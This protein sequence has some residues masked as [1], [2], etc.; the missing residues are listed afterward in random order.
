MRVVLILLLVLF[1]L[2]VYGSRRSRR[3][4]RRRKEAEK[5]NELLKK[6]QYAH[7]K[8][9]LESGACALKPELYDGLYMNDLWNFYQT[10]CIDQTNNSMYNFIIWSTV[11][12]LVIGLIFYIA[13]EVY[14][15]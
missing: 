9:S 1:C 3:R 10:S 8:F 7:S 4:E 6:C 14:Y 11:P 5:R 2:G 13:V 15:R 12:S